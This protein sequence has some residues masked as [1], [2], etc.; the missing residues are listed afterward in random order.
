MALAAT[1]PI[2]LLPV[3]LE[4]RFFEAAARLELRVRI[5]P[6]EIHV[7]THEPE[8]TP[9]ERAAWD[10]WRASARDR[11]AWRDLVDRV[12]VRRATY[13]ASLADDAAPGD[14][15]GAWTRAP[16]ARVLPDRFAVVV[17]LADGTAV[18]VASAPV[19]P[20]PAIGLSPDLGEADP[21]AAWIVDFDRAEADGMAVRIALPVAT[22]GP[23]DVVAFGLRDRDPVREMAALDDLVAAHQFTGGVG[24]L[25][26]G[27]ATNHTAEEAPPWSSLQA[28]AE[29]TYEVATDPAAAA[30]LAGAL[31]VAPA[32]LAR[33]P[34]AAGSSWS[35][36]DDATAAMAKA[37][38]PATLGY[39]FEEMLDGAPGAAA[40][41]RIRQL[42]VV[43]V[44][45]RGPLP[46][47]RVGKNPYGILPVLPLARWRAADDGVVIDDGVDLGMVGVL[48]ALAPRWRDA[49][50]KVPRMPG[51]DDETVTRVL[52]MQPVSSSYIGRSVLGASYA[53]YLHD[54]IRHPL[55]AGWW[56]AQRAAAGAGWSRAKLPPRDTRL[57]RVTYA[58]R[59][60]VVAGPIVQAILDDTPPAYLATLAAAPLDELKTRRALGAATPLLFRL[61]RHAAL[62][63]YLAAARRLLGGK[64]REPELIGLANGLAAPWTWLDA[65]VAGDGTVRALLDAARI[66]GGPVRDPAFRDTWAGLV[67]L[68]TVPARRLD[69]VV[70]E[71]LDLCAHRLDAWIT[72]VAS[73][74]LAAVRTATPRGLH[75]GAYGVA[76]GLVRAKARPPAPPPPGETG[77][78]VEAGAPG[79]FVHAP[80]LGH[81]ATA[82]LLRS[83]YLAHSGETF[84]TDLRSSRVRAARDALD[85]IGAGQ[86]LGQ[87]LG[88]QAERAL[89]DATAPP[90]WSFVPALRRLTAAPGTPFPERTAIDGQELVRR[91]RTGLAW[92]QRGLPAAGSPAALAIERIVAALDEVVDAIGDLLV[93]ESVHQLAQGNP[94]RAAAPLDA[95]A[96]GE[97]PPAELEVLDLPRHGVGIA[98]RVLVLV[99]AG[100][101][102]SGWA[103]SP[104][105]RGEPALEA[106]CAALLGPA[107]AYEVQVR[108]GQSAFQRLT[109]AAL[110]LGAL[111]AVRA[112]RQGELVHRVLDHAQAH[113][114][115]ELP[116]DATPSIDLARVGDRSIDDLVLLGAAV[117]EVLSHARAARPA[118]LTGGD[119]GET[120]LDDAAIAELDGRVA[121]TVLDEALARLASDPRAGLLAAS[122]LGVDGAVPDADP[123]GWPRQVE[124]ARGAL[125]ARRDRLAALPPATTRDER[126]ARAIGRLHLL[127][128]DDAPVAPTFAV[129][130]PALAQSLADQTALVGDDPTEP[131]T[132]LAQVGAVRRAVAP[133][134]RA[135]FVA[136]TLAPGEPALG[137]RVAQLPHAPGAPWIG[138]AVFA[139]APPSA[140]TSLAIHAPLGV[141]LSR[142]VAGLLVDAWSETVPAPVQTTGVAFQVEQPAQ[143]APQVIL[144]AV[145]PG[146]EPAWTEAAVEETIRDALALARIRLVDGDQLADTGQFLPALY[147]AINLAGDTA[148]TDF[149][150]DT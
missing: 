106:W 88:G 76:L 12:G 35:Q 130:Q 54:F 50:A 55:D 48:R 128:G 117:G 13:V 111:D 136:D 115:A 107:F 142:P 42:W 112:A 24:F 87:F 81:A 73:A 97:P 102:A 70:R 75:L 100:A 38:W 61:A 18:R 52:A 99:P 39:F 29:E 131:A 43:H 5:Y 63:S 68:A 124:T 45:S 27:T 23:V 105:A 125:E 138:R 95:L 14:R 126:L 94:T 4:T 32:T 141:D 58:D 103:A 40:I 143:A 119:D 118:D 64:R 135:L 36:V 89:L 53:A 26:A 62:S 71:T 140:R 3:R 127:L 101:R 28:T 83:G 20:E 37:L 57:H 123:A 59:H 84:A 85:A 78:V 144:L 16:R 8:L 11:D 110:G 121:D 22:T 66:G 145:P 139:N 1:L 132:W 74:R 47:L 30:A 133:L 10:R 96:R 15:E 51:A 108:W 34:V 120:P 92:G 9:A 93:A 91:A 2:A 148:S 149:T 33:V 25:A 7:D 72:A 134:D 137:L 31:G 150:E 116:A 19:R 41:E 114:P 67:H 129:T 6:D 104:R 109:I 98:H 90:L 113:R 146:D 60:F 69:A 79:G 77:P 82:A 49:A 44:R 122:M 17:T 46:M 80:A 21:D 147:F 86:S 65:P 56:S